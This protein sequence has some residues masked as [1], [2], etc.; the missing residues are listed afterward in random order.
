MYA[1]QD[2]YNTRMKIEELQKEHPDVFNK[3]G[4]I[5]FNMNRIEGNMISALSTF[6]IHSNPQ[7]ERN[8]V[9]SDALLDKN[10]FPNFENKRQLLI[11]CINAI[12]KVAE[13]NNISFDKAKWLNMCE[14]IRKLQE[15]RNRIAHH[16][17]GFLENGNIS[18][19]ERKSYVELVADKKA[20]RK[21]NGSIRWIEIDL[22]AELK[23]SNDLTDESIG[24]VT[25]FGIESL[26]TLV[27]TGD[28]KFDIKP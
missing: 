22:D 1:C 17:F 27:D 15:V 21:N 19:G 16:S 18:Y 2:C 4:A 14:S 26:N 8:F 20:G 6:F 12:W 25:E 23:R 10:I 13:E 11:K 24:L 3:I 7:S 9:F 5:I 28:L